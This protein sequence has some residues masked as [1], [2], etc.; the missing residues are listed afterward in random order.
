MLGDGVNKITHTKKRT[1]EVNSKMLLVSHARVPSSKAANK[2][3]SYSEHFPS[4]RTLFFKQYT[5]QCFLLY[6]FK[7]K[8]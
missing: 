7:E 1:Q 8:L 2:S 3:E 6:N 4:C 5:R